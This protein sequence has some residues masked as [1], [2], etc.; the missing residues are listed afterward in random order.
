M[1][2]SRL[3]FSPAAAIDAIPE[4]AKL[5]NILADLKFI[6]TDTIGAEFAHVSDTEERLWLQDG[7]QVARMQHRFS[8]EEKKN[9]LWQLTAA[10]GLERYLHTKYVGQ[11]RFS[12]EGGDS[13]IPLLDELVQH[14]GKAGVEETIIGMAHRGRLNVLVNL[15][16]KAPKDLFNEFEG[17]YDL[18]KLR[19]SGDVKYHKGYSADLKTGSGNVHVALAFNPSHLEVVNPVVEGSARARQERRGDA[20][21]DKVLPVQ[22]H[23]DAAFAGQGVV[24]ETLAAVAGARLLHRR[25]G[26]HHHQQP[27]RIHHQRSARRALDAVLLGR[28]E[29]DR[30]A[31][32]ARERR[33]SGGRVLRHPIRTRLSDEISQGC[34]DRPGVLPQARPQRGR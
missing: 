2:I 31:D 18:A 12:L 7:F 28:R 16:G 15:L 29:D 32:P 9:I 10:E 21:G 11:K 34:G 30:G 22:I 4:R 17:Q 5:K 23:G 14:G 26:S 13:L 3:S 25:H 20:L 6:Y 19:G 1:P 8:A 33:R 27:G 24:M